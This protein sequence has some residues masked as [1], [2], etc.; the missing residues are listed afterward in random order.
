MRPS[1]LLF[2]TLTL[3]GC[4]NGGHSTDANLNSETSSKSAGLSSCGAPTPRFPPSCPVS[5]VDWS[6]L[7]KTLQEIPLPS[8]FPFLE[9]PV[10]IGPQRMLLLSAWS[11]SDP[12]EGKGPPTTILKLKEGQWSVFSPAGAIRANGMA[13]NSCGQLF[14]ATHDEQALSQLALVGSGRIDMTKTFQGKTFNSPNDLVIARDGT[15]FWTDPNYQRDQRPGQGNLT[16]VFR[17]GR[18]GSVALLDGAR[19]Q[20]NGITLSPDETKLYVGS[21]EGKIFSY[22]IA[23]DSSVNSASI[24]AEPNQ[25]VDGLTVDCQGNIYAALHEAKEVVIYSPAGAELKRFKLE[26]NVTNLA[27]GG[28]E[29]RTLFITT[30]GRLYQI[31]APLPGAPY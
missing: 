8:N 13:I 14:A 18:D 10:W 4:K 6:G 11:F 17:M 26:A 2:V 21:A 20:P 27:F 16:G 30:A 31:E 29:Q 3:S 25:G 19:Q 28:P 5:P 1:F 24:F 7:E 12:T 9:G 22:Q 23:A 15:L